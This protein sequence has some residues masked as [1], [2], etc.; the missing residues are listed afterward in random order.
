MPRDLIDRLQHFHEGHFRRH[1]A[2]YRELAAGGQQP[3][4]LFVGCSDSRVMPHLLLD[5][6]PGEVF[7]VRNAG[8]LIPPYDG[9]GGYHGTAASIEFAVGVLGVRDIVVCGHSH[10]GALRALYRGV[11]R[12]ARHLEKWL[13]LA[14]E[15][16]LPVQET[17]DAL[18]RVEQRSVVLQIEHLLTYPIVRQRQ[19]RGELGVHGWHYVIETGE[20]SAVDAGQRDFRPVPGIEAAFRT[21]F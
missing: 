5:S 10:C 3:S 17:E 18:R 19:E 16:V 1:E 14:R 13:D 7:I 6:L 2:R 4:V 21:P 8:N 11:P 9:G 15:A 20:V 12:D